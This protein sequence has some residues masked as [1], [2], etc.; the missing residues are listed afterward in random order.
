[1]AKPTSKDDL[2]NEK[3]TAPV[4]PVLLKEWWKHKRT[5]RQMTFN[6]VI[7]A[8]V[9]GAAP[10]IAIGGLILIA[11]GHGS[12]TDVKT[13]LGAITGGGGAVGTVVQQRRR[14]RNR[15]KAGTS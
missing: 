15:S 5:M 8:I 2:R 4:D 9:N 12:A 7:A 6:F 13:I 3:P 11:T 1:L 14:R 10:L